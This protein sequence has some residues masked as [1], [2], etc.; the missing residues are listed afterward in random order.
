MVLTE[1]GA[2]TAVAKALPELTGKVSGSAVRV[3]TPNVSLVI[4]DLFLS[5]S[6][7]REDINECLRLASLKGPLVAQLDY[8]RDEEVV[9]TDMVGNDHPAI[10]DS[11]ATI[12]QG[13][14]ATVYVWYDNEFG[15]SMQVARLAR[16]ISGVE[17]LRY[18]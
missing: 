5:K 18:Y 3:P 14:H 2:A 4:L 11:L 8:T 16:I 10:V 6:V 9:S 1:T 15:Y 13:R 17:R 7:S 12:A